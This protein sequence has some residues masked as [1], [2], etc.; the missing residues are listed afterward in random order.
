MDM[1]AIDSIK[2]KTIESLIV[3]GDTV[4]DKLESFES[5]RLE[6]RLHFHD[7]SNEYCGLRA[8]LD[9][10]NMESKVMNRSDES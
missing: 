7:Q 1:Q 9:W 4:A 10:L 6:L 8:L 3:V 5:Q 2:R